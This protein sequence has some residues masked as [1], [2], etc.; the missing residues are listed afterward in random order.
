MSANKLIIAIDYGGVCSIHSEQ[1]ENNNLDKEIGINMEGCLDAL[2]KLKENGHRLILNSFCGK[3]RAESTRKYFYTLE[4][5]H[6]KPIFDEIYFVKKRDYKK[7]IC[8]KVGADILIDDR[9]DIL[10]LVNPTLTMHF[11]T[12]SSDTDSNF[13]S[14]YQVNNWEEVLKLI[15]TIKSLQRQPT[16]AELK[17][18]VY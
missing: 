16:N 11:G 9:L 8:D 14:D 6:N 15:P 7:H 1:Y 4:A 5:E 2:F 3:K 17:K 13:K 18:Y 10:N 12:H